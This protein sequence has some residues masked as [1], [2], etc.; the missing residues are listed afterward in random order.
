LIAM[1]GGG[2][3]SAIEGLLQ[4]GPTLLDTRTQASGGAGVRLAVMAGARRSP[5]S[6]SR[7]THP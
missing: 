4:S 3:H 5:H 6:Q 7:R 2:Y 1:I